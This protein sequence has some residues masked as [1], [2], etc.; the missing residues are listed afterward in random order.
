MK[1]K[2]NFMKQMPLIITG[3]ILISSCSTY[4]KVACPDFRNNKSYSKKYL[5]NNQV[6]RNLHKNHAVNRE[7]YNAFRINNPRKYKP[8]NSRDYTI[9][10]DK[11]YISESSQ[12]KS[13]PTITEFR[14]PSGRTS[15]KRS[16]MPG[17]QGSSRSASNNSARPSIPTGNGG[18]NDIF[19]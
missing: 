4:D 10:Q 19:G 8:D 13:I 6:K 11:T 5:A 15:F 14:I 18:P 1:H 7:N 2:L 3:L 12:I 16:A 9:N 17:V